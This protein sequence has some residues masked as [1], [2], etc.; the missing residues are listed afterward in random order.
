MSNDADIRQLLNSIWKLHSVLSVIWPKP[1]VPVMAGASTF[2]GT[3]F[4]K[5]LETGI[6]QIDEQLNSYGLNGETRKEL[7]DFWHVVHLLYLRL[8]VQNKLEKSVRIDNAINL[9]YLASG[10]LYHRI[11][12][13]SSITIELAPG[14]SDVEDFEKLLR[15]CNWARTKTTIQEIENSVVTE[16]NTLLETLPHAEQSH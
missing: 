5:S 12:E 2:I 6:R 15:V 1:G 8:R 9:L 13:T 3:N 16:M 10:V 7:C 11:K 14:L 4:F